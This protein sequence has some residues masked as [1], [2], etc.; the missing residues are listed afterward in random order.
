MIGRNA[1]RAL[2]YFEAG[3]VALLCVELARLGDGVGVI[4]SLDYRDVPKPAF[5]IEGVAPI[6]V[7]S[8]RRRFAVDQ[9]GF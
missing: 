9:H 4:D 8:W 7:G 2:P 6:E 3:M 1:S 5:P